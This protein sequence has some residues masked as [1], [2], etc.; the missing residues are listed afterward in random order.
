MRMRSGTKKK[1]MMMKMKYP[2]DQM[3]STDVWQTGE[4][5]SW[6]Y[7]TMANMGAVRLKANSHEMRHVR[8]ALLFV[9]TRP[10]C[11]GKKGKSRIPI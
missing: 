4:T 2:F 3:L 11:E 5:E 10:A 9:Q 6:V 7:C 1:T 8:H